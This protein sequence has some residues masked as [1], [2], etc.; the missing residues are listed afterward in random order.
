MF[1]VRREAIE[2]ESPEEAHE[3]ATD[4]DDV[5]VSEVIRTIAQWA[6]EAHDM[7]C[8]GIHCRHHRAKD[9]LV[10]ISNAVAKCRSGNGG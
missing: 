1:V 4:P 2:R 7:V 6:S 3:C 9:A 10:E 5:A 8:S